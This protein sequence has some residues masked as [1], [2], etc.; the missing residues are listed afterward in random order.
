MTKKSSCLSKSFTDQAF[1]P[2][3]VRPPCQSAVQLRNLVLSE[4]R[5]QAGFKFAAT[6]FVGGLEDIFKLTSKHLG[7]SGKWQRFTEPAVLRKNGK[8]Y[9]ADIFNAERD[10]HILG[11]QKTLNCPLVDCGAGFPAFGAL[12]RRDEIRAATELGRLNDAH[13]LINGVRVHLNTK[14]EAM[15]DSNL[16]TAGLQGVIPYHMP[17]H[18]TGV[19][20]SPTDQALVRVNMHFL[21]MIHMFT[22]AWGLG[23]KKPFFLCGGSPK[24]DLS[25]NV[26]RLN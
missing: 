17:W 24:Y 12:R 25:F 21:N 15:R 6:L 2:E 1:L 10:R 26:I 5:L 22:N 19:F 3:L 18:N 11:L 4:F 23:G 13:S 7:T 8:V 14:L 20:W 16:T 9:T